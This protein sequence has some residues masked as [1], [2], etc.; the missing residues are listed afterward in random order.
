MRKPMKDASDYYWGGRNATFHSEDQI[1][2][3]RM[4]EKWIVPL[5]DTKYDWRRTVSEETISSPKK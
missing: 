5:W 4:L 3:E 2:F 1:W